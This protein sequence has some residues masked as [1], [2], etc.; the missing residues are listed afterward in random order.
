M[1]LIDKEWVWSETCTEGDHAEDCVQVK[2]PCDLSKRPLRKARYSGPNRSGVCVCGHKWDRH[3]LGIIA[4]I[5]YLWTEDAG[6]EGY[7]PQECE[8]Y[9]FNEMGGCDAE[10]NVHCFG[11]KDSMEAQNGT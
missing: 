1:P 9:G 10:G 6:P 4:N 7:L 3:H 5:A 2:R 8:H 11:Y